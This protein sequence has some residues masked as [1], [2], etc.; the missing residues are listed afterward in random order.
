MPPYASSTL[1]PIVVRYLPDH[2]AALR[3]L[4]DDH[5]V[6]D[7]LQKIRRERLKERVGPETGADRRLHIIGHALGIGQLH[8]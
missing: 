5:C 6:D 8:A 1:Q 3:V 7:L 4:L 2:H